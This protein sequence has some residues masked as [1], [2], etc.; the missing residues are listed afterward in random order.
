V[1]EVKPANGTRMFT[2]SSCNYSNTSDLLSECKPGNP[3]GKWQ[4]SGGSGVIIPTMT[5]WLMMRVL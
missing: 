3:V 5:T 2:L 1:I 4:P